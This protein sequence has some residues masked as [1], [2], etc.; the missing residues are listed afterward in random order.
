MGTVNPAECRPAS[1]SYKPLIFVNFMARHFIDRTCVATHAVSSA[2]TL[3]LAVLAS[4]G[5]EMAMDVLLHWHADL[6]CTHEREIPSSQLDHYFIT[7]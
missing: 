4:F 1:G 7:A 3:A 6:P 2:S 5:L